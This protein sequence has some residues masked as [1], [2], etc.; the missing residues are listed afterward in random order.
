MPNSL[1]ASMPARCRSACAWN[2]VGATH[3]AKDHRLPAHS[4]LRT[5]N[6]FRTKITGAC[7]SHVLHGHDLVAVRAPGGR[8]I[9][10][11]AFGLADQRARDRR[12]HRQQAQLDVRLVVADQLVDD[13]VAAL[14][15]LEL[16]GRA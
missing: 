2:S 6:T 11:V 1:A 13:L 15:I 16:Y 14:L 8:H 12:G 7:G 5:P 10:D 9:D 4:T 3:A